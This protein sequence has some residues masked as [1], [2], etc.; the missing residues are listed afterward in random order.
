MTDVYISR[1]QKVPLYVKD[2]EKERLTGTLCL[3]PVDL[4][5]SQVVIQE[6]L[7][8][9]NQKILSL[10]GTDF[11]SYVA[12][13]GTTFGSKEEMKWTLAPEWVLT[14]QEN[15]ILQVRDLRHLGYEENLT[16]FQCSFVPGTFCCPLKTLRF[17]CHSQKR[18][19]L[20]TQRVNFSLRMQKGSVTIHL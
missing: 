3:L 2:Q 7:G 20:L 19:S 13:Q 11:R 8:F 16:N 4:A 17:T 9:K 6:Y 10:H 5:S 18:G 1:L 14:A 12:D 15:P